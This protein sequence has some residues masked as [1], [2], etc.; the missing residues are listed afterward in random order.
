MYL[1]TFE[2][3]GLVW[4]CRASCS[5][6]DR[7]FWSIFD[8][9]DL[10]PSDEHEGCV[11]VAPVAILSVGRQLATDWISLWIKLGIEEIERY[12]RKKWEKQQHTSKWKPIYR[13]TLSACVLFIS[14]RYMLPRKTF[15]SPLLEYN[16][17]ERKR[18]SD[19]M[20]HFPL[21][22]QQNSNCKN[23]QS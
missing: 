11:I 19:K 2:R 17:I 20:K 22:A 16:H 6:F 5:L 12:L 23:D 3:R 4:D 18:T 1:S 15:E 7:I 14:L 13:S 21:T 9:K 10:C 8:L